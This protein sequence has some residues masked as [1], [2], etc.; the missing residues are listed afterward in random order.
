MNFS[1]LNLTR[2]EAKVLRYLIHF[3]WHLPKPGITRAVIN[4]RFHFGPSTTD[5]LVNSLVKMKLI[6]E[7]PHDSGIYADEIQITSKG[8]E[9]V[10]YMKENLLSKLLWNL[11]IP[12]LASVITSII[13]IKLVSQ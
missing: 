9:Y 13:T 6:V 2:N 3:F 5:Y 7:Y 10:N 4:N 8:E 11:F 12:I 1:E